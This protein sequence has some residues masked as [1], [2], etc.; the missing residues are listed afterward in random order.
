MT[1]HSDHPT[2]EQ[3][4]GFSRGQLPP[5]DAELIETHVGECEPCCET[6]LGLSSDDTFVALLQEASQPQ[7]DETLRRFAHSQ[8]AL[9]SLDDGASQLIDHP[10]YTIVAPVGNG[11]M[12]NV[13]KAEHK[14]MERTVALK[15]IKRELFRKPE[16]V[17]R[18]HREVK[19]AAR[20]SHSNI[21]T[22]Y[23]A[24]Q[25]G[26]VH[27][28][29]ME[30]VDGVD[31]A[32]HVK[33]AGALPI[34]KACDYIRQAALGLQH[35]HDQ[36]MVHRDIK[37]H[38]LM[39]SNDGTVKI[40]DF[41]LA[42]LATEAIGHEGADESAGDDGAAS[43]AS[44]LTTLG[45][46]MG[47]P[48][49]ISP[50]QA[51]E[52]HAV[53]IRSDIYS[54]GCTFY[55]LLT[56][57]TPFAEG[58]AMERIKAHREA[59]PE[60]IEHLCD[61]IPSELAEIV[62]RMMTKEL[63]KRF[64]TP[65]EVADALAQ[66]VDAH[67]TVP[68]PRRDTK[69][70]PG[71][72][73]SQ[74]SWW[75]PALVS[76]LA[77]VGC[78][79]AGVIYV[80]TNY[81]T[82]VVNSTDSSV[83][84]LIR[85]ANDETKKGQENVEIRIVDTVTGSTVKHLRP[86]HYVLELKGDDNTFEVT[87][88][89]FSLKR[90]EKVL[91]T[92]TRIKS[93]APV[94][95]RLLASDSMD[96]GNFYEMMPS[97]DGSCVAYSEGGFGPL[98]VRNLQTGVNRSLVEGV[99]S[100]APVWSPDG[101]RIAFHDDREGLRIVDVDAAKVSTPAGTGGRTLMPRDWSSDG[102]LVCTWK[103]PEKGHALVIVSVS[104]GEIRRL[105]DI[106]GPLRTQAAFS[107]D[108]RHVVYSTPQ[109]QDQHVFIIATNGTSPS[110]R[111]TNGPGTNTNPLWSPDGRTLIYSTG[112]GIYA[113]SVIDGRPEGPPRFVKR[114]LDT[115]LCW[116]ANAGLCYVEF[117]HVSN[118]NAL[119]VN[120]K[121]GEAIDKPLL[122]LDGVEG[123]RRF[124]WSPDMKRI[125]AAG[126]SKKLL[127]YSTVDRTL[128][129]LPIESD[130]IFKLW[131]SGDGEHV[132][133]TESL[134]A[135]GV[136]FSVE[137]TNGTATPLTPHRADRGM[138]ELSNDGRRLLFYRGLGVGTGGRAGPRQLVVTDDLDGDTDVL[139]L[140]DEQEE[141]K[142][143]PHFMLSNWVRPRYSTH[144]T[145]ALFGTMNG[146]IWVVAVDGS[147][148]RK[149]ATVH[150]DDQQGTYLRYAVWHPEGRYIAYDDRKSIHVV[151]VQTGESRV[152]LPAGVS[153]GSLG[154]TQWSPDGKFIGYRA[155]SVHPE[156]WTVKN[157]LGDDHRE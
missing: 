45:T 84:I 98:L 54:L 60:P 108:G 35:A 25:A 12:G 153:P 124:S 129:T 44:R 87:P 55:Y 48:D 155:E 15:V 92:V 154:I 57:R 7:S 94:A 136:I 3:L 6:L 51:G 69:F 5:E 101:K 107:P 126:G 104:D 93:S 8:D 64:Q 100:R 85:P 53:D 50:E 30:Y 142:A 13:F 141:R 149:V 47:T 90:S 99:L 157:L 62:R 61:D 2:L 67:R 59:E 28:L 37:P 123:A 22:A 31:L 32:R 80:A 21:V 152:V 151:N 20:L 145:H 81:G 118:F 49:F 19:T 132:L 109:G 43:K 86:G 114:S 119:P 56:G 96:V 83:E 140:V 16:A 82:L 29:V 46:M 120:P 75:P 42:T 68:A 74:R 26:D 88:H 77:L 95:Q 156:L 41:G 89:R 147:S 72:A 34:A 113:I 122:V 76:V 116:S 79:L 17:T 27:F 117:N 133:Y 36:G 134:R 110:L 106:G 135:R 63:D 38:N 115:P 111:V 125:A 52:P 9:V 10:R 105:V 70:R 4:S 73:S 78:A 71:T 144:G 1:E 66:F 146:E 103:V 18:F 150:T 23:D 127:L 138:M 139:V 91:V 40:L 33:D 102:N 39:L 11:G 58:S 24:E 128:Q 137:L 14:M 131:W 121:T 148:K 65:S 97:P 143:H 112:E 130:R